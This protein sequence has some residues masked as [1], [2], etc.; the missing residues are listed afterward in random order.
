MGGITLVTIKTHALAN[1][2]GATQIVAYHH[3]FLWN[4]TIQTYF[5]YQPDVPMERKCILEYVP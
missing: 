3:A 1:D 4:A 2:I 5:F